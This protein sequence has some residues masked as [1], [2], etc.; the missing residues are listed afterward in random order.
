MTRSVAIV[1]DSTADLPPD[2]TRSRAI[3]VV[4]LTLNFDGQALLDGV[5]IRPDEFYRR[6]ANIGRVAA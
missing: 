3:T 5:D 2:L 4:P 1:T 6:L